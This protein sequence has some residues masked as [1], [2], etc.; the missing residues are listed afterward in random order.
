[1]KRI[2]VFAFALLPGF[3]IRI[4]SHSQASNVAPAARDEIAGEGRSPNDGYTSAYQ[5]PDWK[6][7]RPIDA[8]FAFNH[9]AQ[10]GVAGL[11]T[12]IFMQTLPCMGCL[13]NCCTKVILKPGQSKIICAESGRIESIGDT[14]ILWEVRDGQKSDAPICA[15]AVKIE[16]WGVRAGLIQ[17]P[18]I[19]A[20]KPDQ[21]FDHP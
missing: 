2:V 10:F 16:G 12:I 19:K 5:L 17:A 1:M 7:E 13:P 9:P 21:P 14:G 20:D 3:G 18:R 15:N 4:F 8:E 6:T 11:E